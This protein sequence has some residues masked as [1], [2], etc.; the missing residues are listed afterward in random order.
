MHSGPVGPA[1]PPAPLA[2]RVNWCHRSLSPHAL[3]AS[4]QPL[5]LP[6]RMV[7]TRRIVCEGQSGGPFVLRTRAFPV[8]SVGVDEH[9]VDL[10]QNF[11]GVPGRV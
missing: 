1:S 7:F 5:P 3:T 10:C 2:A 8:A 6:G 11:V 9:G 4:A